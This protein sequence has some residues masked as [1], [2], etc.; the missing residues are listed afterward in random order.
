MHRR[1]DTH[2]EFE[3]ADFASEGYAGVFRPNIISGKGIGGTAYDRKN[4]NILA[5]SG[6][7]KVQGKRF[8]LISVKGL[9]PDPELFAYI[10]DKGRAVEFCVRDIKS[11]IMSGNMHRIAFFARAVRS[12]KVPYVFTSGARNIYEVKA[13]RE[14][15]FIGELLGFTQR[16]V[17]RSMGEVVEE[18]FGD[19]E[20]LKDK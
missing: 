2:I 11:A 14:I 16:D 3:W 9:A 10:R 13:P 6:N 18:L 7:E 5:H 19:R 12:Y 20:W 15:A 1:Y 8:D 4:V 17:I